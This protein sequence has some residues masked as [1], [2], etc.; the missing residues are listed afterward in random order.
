M[1]GVGTA[2]S[3]VA[4]WLAKRLDT[5]RV[6]DVG[7]RGSRSPWR[8][9]RPLCEVIGCDPLRGSLDG[10]PSASGCSTCYPFAVAANAGTATLHV[11][12]DPDC[13]SLL[14]P[15]W[16]ILE[17]YNYAWRFEVQRELEVTCITLEDL[18]QRHGS[19]D[20]V[21]LD[22][23]GLE[24]QLIS[25]GMDVIAGALCLDVEAGLLENY[26]GEYPYGM[27]DPLLREAGFSMIDFRPLFSR[28]AGWRE[29][30]SKHQPLWC[31]TIWL[32][33][34]V[35]R[36]EIPDETAA[37][38]LMLICKALGH[39]AYGQELAIFLGEE[40][41]LPALVAARLTDEATWQEPWQI[42]DWRG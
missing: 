11:A 1:H 33:D 31:E 17:R 3:P 20:V 30:E 4:E 5:I 38:K 19:F 9:L 39:F 37:A 14:R 35:G 21:K 27:I 29:G 13:S 40:N 25:S 22:S 41:A 6:V 16:Q 18:Q 34:I 28:R 12:A 2:A 7:C 10:S 36:A 26:V 32:R 23:Q 8:E 15:N 24:Y 42:G